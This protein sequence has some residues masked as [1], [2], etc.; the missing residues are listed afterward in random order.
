LE[1]ARKIG[2]GGAIS[3]EGVKTFFEKSRSYL[4]SYRGQNLCL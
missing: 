2:R 4:F 1:E 3:R